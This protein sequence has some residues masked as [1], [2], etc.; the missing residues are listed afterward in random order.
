MGQRAI[1]D[2][3]TLEYYEVI[4]LEAKFLILW[5]QEKLEKWLGRWPHT[6]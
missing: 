4:V 5:M 3:P 6:N 2:S 1:E